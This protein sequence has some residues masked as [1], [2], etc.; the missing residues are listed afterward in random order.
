MYIPADSS[1]APA[2]WVIDIPEGKD[3]ECLTQR[4][5]IHFK[6]NGA[7][8]RS[9]QRAMMADQFKKFAPGQVPKSCVAWLQAVCSPLRV[10]RRLLMTP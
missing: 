6:K 10:A 9:A 5:K 2:E 4:L 1:A 7:M 8:D 3:I